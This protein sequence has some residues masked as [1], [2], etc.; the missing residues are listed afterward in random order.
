MKSPG[1]LRIAPEMHTEAVHVAL[2][3]IRYRACQHTQALA[4]IQH[5]GCTLL[6]HISYDE[7]SGDLLA[8]DVVQ[9]PG[10]E[11]FPEPEQSA[12]GVKVP[13]WVQTDEVWETKLSCTRI[14]QKRK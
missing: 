10:R 7:M 9:H 14:G 12:K 5:N 3:R 2:T 13:K 1:L 8:P 6:F 4:C 11:T